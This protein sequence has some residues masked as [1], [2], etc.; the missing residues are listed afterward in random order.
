MYLLI[1]SIITYHQWPSYRSIISDVSIYTY[2]S[3]YVYLSISISFSIYIPHVCARE[4]LL[5]GIGLCNYGGSNSRLGRFETQEL[6]LQFMAKSREKIKQKSGVGAQSSQVRGVFYHPLEHQSVILFS[7]STDWIRPTHIWEI[8]VLY[9]I[10][11]F[12]D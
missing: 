6:L 9:L 8:N 5:W 4:M 10:Y 3:I 2:I 1:I 11:L 12:K 7:P